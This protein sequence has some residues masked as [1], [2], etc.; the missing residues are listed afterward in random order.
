LGHQV[1]VVTLIADEKEQKDVEELKIICEKVIAVEMPVWH[2]L[3]NALLAIMQHVPM[4]SRYSW[5]PSL[6]GEVTSTM[7]YFNQQ[8]KF[9]VVHIEHLRG[10]YYGF[11]LRDWI[12][13]H[14]GK[15]ALPMVWDSVD[16][17]S[18]L[19]RQ[20]SQNSHGVKSRVIALL[21]TRPTER[22][23]RLGLQTFDQIL[24]TSPKDR[25]ELLALAQGEQTSVEVLP[26]GVDLNYFTPANLIRFEDTIV[27]TG[28]M[29]YHANIAMVEHLVTKIMPLV[30]AKR[31]N[32]KLQIV[33]KDPP[34]SIQL[35]NDHPNIVVTGTV[36]D[37]RPY[38]QQATLAVVPITYGA[39][40]QNKILEAMACATPVVVST[41]AVASLLAI[42]GQD[43]LKAETPSEFAEAILAL[44]EDPQ[45]RMKLGKAGR[46]YVEQ[47]HDWLQITSKLVDLY[48]TTI[49]T[50]QLR[51][52]GA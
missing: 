39:G 15:G 10:M 47:N 35:L 45:Q 49:N 37:I 5:N 11:R 18:H 17:I 28:K 30:W 7:D 1:T 34:R 38:L 32:I 14:N 24:V 8:E 3:L 13:Q 51:I 43:F 42:P 29:S 31:N 40:I 22:Y 25:E 36:S 33:G 48:N 16:C 12:R 9:D 19:M 41:R 44:I 4:Q 26:N 46:L 6:F 50:K 21:E 20:A 52:R 2:S 27:I 23:E